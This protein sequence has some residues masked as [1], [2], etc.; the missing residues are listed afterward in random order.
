[1]SDNDPQ[2]PESDAEAT[3]APGT[4]ATHPAPDAESSPAPST[5]AA[6]APAEAPDGPAEV[7]ASADSAEREES[8]TA[9][10]EPGKIMRIGT[11]AKQLLEEV[12]QVELDEA[13]R[14]RLAEIH[15][16][17]VDE[18]AEGMSDDLVEELER[19]DLSFDADET[20]SYGE[21]RVAQAQLVGWLE[22][23]FHGI[24]TAIMAQQALAAQH[25]GQQGLPPGM[26]VVPDQSTEGRAQTP[27]R[28][29]GHSGTG[30]YL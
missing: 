29:D 30:N 19:L 2:Q 22:G 3:P 11:M 27:T 17:T 20:P 9:I 24:Q 14:K 5:E 7:G 1:M 25:G 23:L 13:G 15:R 4:E 28:D 6:P 16:R 18:L 21:L 8:G 26:M 10:S 12:R